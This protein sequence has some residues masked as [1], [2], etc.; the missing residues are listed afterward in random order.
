M[1]AFSITSASWTS[2]SARR[3]TREAPSPGSSPSH[4]AATSDRS[5]MRNNAWPACSRTARRREGLTLLCVCALTAGVPLR[6]PAQSSAYEEL[7]TFSAVLNHIR[8]NYADSV[9]Y[10]ELVRAAIDGMLRMLDPHS[11]FVSRREWEQRSALERG[12]LAVTGYLRLAWFGPKAGDEVNDA[13]QRLTRQ[14][15]RQVILDLRNNPGGIVDAAVD[16]AAAFLP[17]GAVVFRTKGRKADAGHEYITKRDG[18]FRNVPLIVIVNQ[19]SASAAEALAGSLQDHDRALILGRR[20][21]GKALVQT[22]FFI[23]PSGDMVEL[24]I[25]RVFTPSGRVIQRRDKGI[26]G[27]QHWSF[28]GKSGAAEDTVSSFQ[29]D[30]G[31]EMRGGGGIVPDV[32]LPAPLSL[33][34]WWSVAT[35]SGFDVAIADSVAQ[36]LP[37]T[38]AGRAQWL[39]GREQWKTRVLAPFLDRV[40]ARLHVTAQPD[41][42]LADRL[43]LLLA[44]RAATVRWPPDAGEELRTH[45]DPDIQA[46]M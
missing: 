24:T 41:S 11:Y 45:N 44:A 10:R 15:A 1:H 27:G 31:R 20:S 36:A 16:I 43:A 46:A 23:V 26:G 30:H 32:M 28:A 33:P 29:T 22:G 2:S 13:L 6:L 34:A 14:G 5:P 18:G 38:P 7:Q 8:L 19:R 39:G 21:F 37:R 42:L 17:R 4:P 12:E 3:T 25:A 35:D 9:T 40:R